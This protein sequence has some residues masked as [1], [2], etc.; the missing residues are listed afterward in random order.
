MK[1][2]SILLATITLCWSCSQP[3]SNK[4][5]TETNTAEELQ[6]E[7]VADNSTYLDDPVVK[8][9]LFFYLRRNVINVDRNTFV[10]YEELILKGNDFKYISVTADHG[11]MH[12][13]AFQQSN[14]LIQFASYSSNQYLSNEELGDTVMISGT[15]QLENLETSGLENGSK[16]LS[17]KLSAEVESYYLHSSPYAYGETERLYDAYQIEENLIIK[18]DEPKIY[19][20]DE[21]YLKARIQLLTKEELSNF[22]SED[23]AYLRNELFA[24][25]GH[26]FRT[27]KMQDHFMDQTWYTPYFE[28]ATNLLNEIEKE[29]A[30]FIKSLEG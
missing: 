9:N 17:L 10:K 3:S 24:R 6:E 20:R 18:L 15:I 28:D 11:V 26:M 22:S 30:L 21:L 2:L 8:E 16:Q 29:N 1:N 23:L 5:E 7:V 14:Q 4:Q 13:Y 19:N 12:N 27:E 25:H